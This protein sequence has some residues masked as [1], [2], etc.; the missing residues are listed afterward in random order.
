METQKPIYSLKQDSAPGKYLSRKGRKTMAGV[1]LAELLTGLFL[2]NLLFL[3]V[4]SAA[5]AA[6]SSYQVIST[7]QEQVD[8]TNKL[9]QVLR[10]PLDASQVRYAL[11]TVRLH[12]SGIILGLDGTPHPIYRRASE[13]TPK[14]GSDAISFLE[15]EQNLIFHVLNAGFSEHS[16]EQSFVLCSANKPTVNLNQLNYW[17][18]LG[19]DGYIEAQGS[20]RRI[21]DRLHDCRGGRKFRGTLSLA[22]HPMFGRKNSQRTSD[23]AV[24][25]SEEERLTL[26]ARTINLLPVKEC[27]TIYI[28]RKMRLRRLAHNSQENQPIA[29]GFNTLRFALSTASGASKTINVSVVLTKS[30]GTRGETYEFRLTYPGENSSSLLDLLI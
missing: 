28:D 27:Y 11:T 13:T 19:V 18:A 2:A 16:R 24:Y 30:L 14:E 6:L 20:V 7:K 4:L 17:L 5:R 23:P 10:I 3:L 26:F 8:K 21:A 1:A 25:L 22:S 15:L 9:R 29:D 12:S